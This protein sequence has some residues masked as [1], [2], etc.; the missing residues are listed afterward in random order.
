MRALGVFSTARASF[1][2]H[3]DRDDVDAL[4]EGLRKARDFFGPS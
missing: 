2:I 4:V 3:N 1:Y